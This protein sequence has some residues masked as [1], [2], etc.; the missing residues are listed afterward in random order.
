M[1]RYILI[2][3]AFGLLYSCQKTDSVSSVDEMVE[4]AGVGLKSI[5]VE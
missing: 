5:E 4:L 2:I 3:V 1:K